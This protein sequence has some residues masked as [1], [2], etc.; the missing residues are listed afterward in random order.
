MT[1]PAVN[2]AAYQL[3]WFALVLSA[4][5]QKSWMGIALGLVVIGAHLWAVRRSA[6]R[7]LIGTAFVWGLVVESGFQA[8]GLLRY[9]SGFDSVTWVAPLWIVTLWA[10]FA[11]TLRH[12]LRW[13]LH[14][15][16]LA[17]VL[18]AAFGPLAFRAGEAMGA[19]Q[20][21]PD[22]W[23][24]YLGLAVLWGVSLPALCLITGRQRP[25]A[26]VPE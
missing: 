8:T 11:T 25:I 19:V 13:L 12:S 1:H 16:L 20:F 10:L 7:R 9:S 2:F 6:E 26:E 22:R 3:G 24:S 18:G 17:A 5:A 23:T 14:R 4:A 21:A 15:P